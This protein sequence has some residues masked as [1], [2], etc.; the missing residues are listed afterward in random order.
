MTCSFGDRV[1][2]GG[3]F[4]GPEVCFVHGHRWKVGCVPKDEV[5]ALK[6]LRAKVAEVSFDHR[7]LMAMGGEQVAGRCHGI[8]MDVAP[9]DV[10]AVRGH[11]DHQS[12][13]AHA[14]FEHR[15]ASARSK[16]EQGMGQQIGVFSRRINGRRDGEVPGASFGVFPADL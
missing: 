15:S 10:P 7:T 1:G 5:S 9:G 12:A 8:G 3:L 6:N 13:A 11:L 2:K 14:H 4:Q 16:V